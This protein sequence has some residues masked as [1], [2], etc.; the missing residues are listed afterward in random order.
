MRVLEEKGK[1]YTNLPIKI[2]NRSKVKL[3]RF[4]ELKSESQT[5]KP[6]NKILNF[7]AQIL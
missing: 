4:K 2:R 1:N 6:E 3:L 7:D 5:T